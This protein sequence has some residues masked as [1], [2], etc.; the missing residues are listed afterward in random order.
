M[1]CQSLTFS[2]ITEDHFSVIV[3]RVAEA[4]ID[5][6]GHSGQRSRAG[7]TIRWT[8]EPS[9]EVLTIQCVGRPFFV[10]CTTINDRIQSLVGRVL[11]A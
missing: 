7:L 9:R 3:A 8:F 10:G 4:G 5:L 11:R 2:G 1:S 6:D